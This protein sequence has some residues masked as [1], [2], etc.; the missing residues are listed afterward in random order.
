MT[1]FVACKSGT[2]PCVSDILKTAYRMM[3]TD[4]FNKRVQQTAA[5]AE[6]D[7]LRCID[8]EGA[9]KLAVIQYV[10]NLG[11]VY[12]TEIRVIREDAV[13]DSRTGMSVSYYNVYDTDQKHEEVAQENQ[14]NLENFVSESERSVYES[15]WF[16]DGKFDP[17]KA[18]PGEGTTSIIY[19]VPVPTEAPITYEVT[20]TYADII[21]N[22]G[23]L[24]GYRIE[25]TN[26]EKL[27]EGIVNKDIDPAT[28]LT[29]NSEP[30][31]EIARLAKNNSTATSVN[32]SQ[33]TLDSDGKFTAQVLKMIKSACAGGTGNPTFSSETTNARGEQAGG[34]KVT[35]TIT[36]GEVDNSAS[37]PMERR[38]Q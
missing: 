33:S 19:N 7:V 17:F 2:A 12:K 3:Q 9:E 11:N 21:D 31:K 15:T 34:T 35:I 14:Q 6:N 13:S 23:L 24:N 38:G 10:D 1:T 25:K 29:K 26:S 20:M 37:I 28:V 5:R 27:T 16:T 4:V 30:I 18:K 8:L 32:V 36:G 22:T